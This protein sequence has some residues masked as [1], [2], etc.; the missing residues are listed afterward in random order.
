MNAAYLPSSIR[1]PSTFSNTVGKTPSSYGSTMETAPTSSV[2]VRGSASGLSLVAT[3]C[4]GSAAPRTWFEIAEFT[5]APG[6][7]RR[8][9]VP[10]RPPVGT[11]MGSC[12]TACRSLEPSREAARRFMLERLYA[13]EA[14]AT[15]WQTIQHSEVRKKHLRTYLLP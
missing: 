9:P 2:R 1:L 10:N 4:A 14:N 3:C 5:L 7:A 15:S 11:A 6:S 8:L 12:E 13:V